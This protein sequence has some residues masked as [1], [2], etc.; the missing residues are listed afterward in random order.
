[1]SSK[2]DP[3]LK[4]RS[5][6][7]V[8]ASRDPISMSGRLYRNLRDRFRGPV[9]PINPRAATIESAPAFA[10]VLEVPEP[11]DL[12]FVIVPAVHVLDVVRWD[13][14]LAR[15]S[16]S[17]GFRLLVRLQPQGR[18]TGVETFSIRLPPN[19]ACN[20]SKHTALQ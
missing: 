13:G 14:R 19:R 10:S 16:F 12:A 6:A 8:G 17:A 18:P 7:V 1:V 15:F 3:I 9:Y 2:L 11:V 5:V 4:P 20:F